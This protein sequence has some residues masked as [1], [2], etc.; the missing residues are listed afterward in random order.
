MRKSA[1]RMPKSH[2]RMRKPTLECQFA[3]AECQNALLECWNSRGQNAKKPYQNAKTHS[4]MP[5]CQRRMRKR[6]AGIWAFAC[7]ECGP[8]IQNAKRHPRMRNLP[9]ENGKS[10]FSECWLTSGNA[11]SFILRTLRNGSFG[12]FNILEKPKSI[13][14]NFD[15]LLVSWYNQFS[16]FKSLCA[17]LWW[18]LADSPCTLFSAIKLHVFWPFLGYTGYPVMGTASSPDS[19]WPCQK[20]SEWYTGYQELSTASRDHTSRTHIESWWLITG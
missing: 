20:Y 16:S 3:N 7:P 2:A 13:S 1:A 15:L 5:I 14:F 9:L 18:V 10:Q 19:P 17:T 8:H 6:T 11:E 4:G 12:N